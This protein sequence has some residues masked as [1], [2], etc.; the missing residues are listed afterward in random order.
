M[1]ECQYDRMRVAI[2]RSGESKKSEIISFSPKS[3]QSI[4]CRV[5]IP[6]YGVVQIPT[7]ILENRMAD[8]P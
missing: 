5:I 8:C 2:S 1:A 7:K 6:E 4:S 3:S